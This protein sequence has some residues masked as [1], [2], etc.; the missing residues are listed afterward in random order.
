MLYV[1]TLYPEYISTIQE[2]K[3]QKEDAREMLRMA[4]KKYVDQEIEHAPQEWLDG[5]ESK[6]NAPEKAIEISIELQSESQAI[7]KKIKD[8]MDQFE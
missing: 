7:E 2:D 4:Q 8:L 3:K 6:L 5:F 1:T